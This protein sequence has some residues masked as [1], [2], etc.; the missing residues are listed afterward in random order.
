L[1]LGV[2]LWSG[3]MLTR[4]WGGWVQEPS[5]TASATWAP[6]DYS[7]KGFFCP[8]FACGVLD[9]SFFLCAAEEHIN[10]GFQGLK[11][12]EFVKTSRVL[13]CL[14]IL[15]TKFSAT[16]EYLQTGFMSRYGKARTRLLHLESK[17]LRN[18]LNTGRNLHKKFCMWWSLYFLKF[19]FLIF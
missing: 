5:V 9:I 1:E 14:K 10:K 11:E 12:N 6:W 8:S 19:I 17:L 16:S 18:M 2:W 7:A 4:G 3:M 13:Q 15:Q